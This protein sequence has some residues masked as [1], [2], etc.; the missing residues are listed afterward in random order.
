MTMLRT[1]K[2]NLDVLAMDDLM[3]FIKVPDEDPKR[4]NNGFPLEIF[5][6]KR[7]ILNLQRVYCS[8]LLG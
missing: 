4:A 8:I 3:L 7:R 2:D 5:E 1:L 6:M